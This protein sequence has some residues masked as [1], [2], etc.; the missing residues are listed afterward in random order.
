[1][2]AVRVGT[3]LKKT[4]EINGTVTIWR[5]KTLSILKSLEHKT[6]LFFFLAVWFMCKRAAY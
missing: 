6:N 1:M 5:I 3:F 4:Y 2:G